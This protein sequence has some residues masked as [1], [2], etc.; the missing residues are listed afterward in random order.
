MCVRPGGATLGGYHIPNGAM[1]I[2][3]TTPIHRDPRHYPNPEAFRPARFLGTGWPATSLPVGAPG[4]PR[5]AVMPFGA[6]QRT[7]VGQRFAVLEAV[8]LL[9]AISKRFELSLPHLEGVGSPPDSV[10]GVGGGSGGDG[11]SRVGGSS[12]DA[13]GAGACVGAC[14][15]AGAAGAA[16]AA[17]VQTKAGGGGDPMRE[18]LAIT[19]RPLHLRLV[20]KKRAR[21]AA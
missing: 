21:A 16:K 10:G 18:H 6:G 12:F 13:A 11:G 15:K 9:A 2:V 20:L 19:L 5:F 3:N 1:V 14:A 7:C 8:V 17:D 4:G